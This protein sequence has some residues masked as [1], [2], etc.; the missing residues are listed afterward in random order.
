MKT[1][2][3]LILGMI[4]VMVVG[5]LIYFTSTEVPTVETPPVVVTEDSI[6][7]C[8]VSKLAKD[9]YVLRIESETNGIVSGK[10]A[11]N[12]FEK[13]SSSGSFT[14]TYANGILFGDY[15]F[16]SEGL[17][18]DMQVIFKKEGQSFVRGY[19]SVKNEGEKVTFENLNA[20]SY[21]ANSTFIKSA[22]CRE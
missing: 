16:D 5:L 10:L 17:H 2:V 12:N 15:S 13:D 21:D 20:I 1:N 9:I 19:G 18:S 22:D 3:K 6:L 8:Y 11:F 7:G 14:G 4:F